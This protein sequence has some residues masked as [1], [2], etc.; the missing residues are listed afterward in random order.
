MVLSGDL[1]HRIYVARRETFCE[2]KQVRQLC[3]IAWGEVD[4]YTIMFIR[5]WRAMRG[6]QYSHDIRRKLRM[7]LYIRSF[8][9]FCLNNN[10]LIFSNKL[11]RDPIKGIPHWT[12]NSYTI[13]A[14]SSNPHPVS[15]SIMLFIKKMH[16]FFYSTLPTFQVHTNRNFWT[17]AIY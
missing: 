7:L 3:E 6:H 14:P 5:R 11:L 13:T 10:I 12:A 4:L 1:S 16:W 8:M 17:C 9:S 2:K 15:L